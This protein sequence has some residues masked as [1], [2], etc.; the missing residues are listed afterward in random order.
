MPDPYAFL[1]EISIILLTQNAG[2]GLEQTLAQIF[3]Q[4]ASRTFEV[5]AIDS[6]S[7]DSTLETLHRFQVRIHQIPPHEFNFGSTRELGYELARG[8]YLV[9]LSQDCVPASEQWLERL[10]APFDDPTVAA[11]AG[12]P[13]LPPS[14]AR[15]LYWERIDRFYFTR[16]TKRWIAKYHFGFSNTNSAIRKVVWEQNRLGAIEICED[17]LLQ[18]TWTARGLKIVFVPEATG[19]HAHDYNLRELARRC[20]NEGLGCRLVGEQYTFVDC[21]S[22]MLNLSNLATLLSAMARGARP[23][24]AELLFP[25]IR[26]FF[27]WKG[28]HRTRRYVRG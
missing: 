25:L 6:G 10:T 22:D 11:V 26:P 17:R 2:A 4:R 3:K 12:A 21:L 1:P 5:I 18:K 20:E 13:L 27:L 23:T 28:Y 8:G 9:T 16:E 7:T 14:P 24:G 19:Y 15:I